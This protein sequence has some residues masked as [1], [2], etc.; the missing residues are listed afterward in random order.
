MKKRRGEERLEGGV[1]VSLLLKGKGK[2]AR[3]TSKT[4]RD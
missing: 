4:E 1:L 3:G 2:A